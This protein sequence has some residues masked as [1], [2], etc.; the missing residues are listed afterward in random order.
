MQIAPGQAPLS[1][2][3]L[4]TLGS[5]AAPAAAKTAAAPAA[6]PAG[7]N[8]APA[9]GDLAGGRPLPRGSLVDLRA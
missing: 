4:K 8:A 1:L 7:E 9:A 6:K 2:A 5:Q 3:I